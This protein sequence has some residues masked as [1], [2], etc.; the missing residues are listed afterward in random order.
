MTMSVRDDDDIEKARLAIAVINTV[1]PAALCRP[2]STTLLVSGRPH[3][4]AL[5]RPTHEAL[6]RLSAL[7]RTPR[8][9]AKV[10][11]MGPAA[12]NAVVQVATNAGP[13]VV[14]SR[15]DTKDPIDEEVW[16]LSHAPAKIVPR[17]VAAAS[18]EALVATAIRR[19]AFDDAKALERLPTQSIVME[20]V[21]GAAPN[22]CD[23]NALSRTAQALAVLH[24]KRPT[25]GPP[26]RAGRSLSSCVRLSFRLLATLSEANVV[27]KQATKDIERSLKRW[28]EQADKLLD[29]HRVPPSLCHGDLRLHNVLDDGRRATL[30]DLE[31]AG[32]SDPALDIALFRARTPLS[33]NAELTFVDA[34]LDA[35]F[36]IGSKKQAAFLKRYALARPIALALSGLAAGADVLDVIEGRRSTGENITTFVDDK[37]QA[38]AEDLSAAFSAAIVPTFPQRRAAARA[39]RSKSPGTPR[40][41]PRGKQRPTKRPQLSGGVAFDGTGASG[42][43]VLAKAAAQRLHL[44]WR[45]TGAAFR[46][47][48]LR[49]LELGCVPP[50]DVDAKSAALNEAALHAAAEKVVG[51]FKGESIVL[52]DDGAVRH[53]GSRVEL[54]LEVWAVEQTVAQWA[55]A[56]ATRDFL[57]PVLFKAIESDAVVEGRAVTTDLWPAAAVRIF[58]DASVDVR[59]KRTWERLWQPPSRAVVKSTLRERDRQDRAR[60]LSPLVH[61]ADVPLVDTTRV[62]EKKSIEQVLALID[63]AA[64]GRRR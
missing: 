6:A 32:L 34:Y 47:F 43:S 60:E 16:A 55:R 48:A 61:A 37:R 4:L 2:K 30:I 50:T 24:Q 41:K 8:R 63:A 23:A 45:N 35:S 38:C 40:G 3:L 5:A 17:L 33:A 18:H 7:T 31:H 20:H 54:S 9:K 25:K 27:D 21:G 42:K 14:K 44:P 56:K 19:H 29:L 12:A 46:L 1:A 64:S 49:A 26:I 10:L 62:S 36:R 52:T 57:A 28:Q 15:I 53:N 22:A 11:P 58:V 39:T 51:S 59:A 13:V